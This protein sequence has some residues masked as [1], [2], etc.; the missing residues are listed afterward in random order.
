MWKPRLSRPRLEAV[1]AAWLP[2]EQKHP[3]PLI[4]GLEVPEDF[5]PQTNT[6]NL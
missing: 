3:R 6:V 2:G 5:D 1:E 4:G